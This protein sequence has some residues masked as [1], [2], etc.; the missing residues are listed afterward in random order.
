MTSRIKNKKHTTYKAY[1]PRWNNPQP[2]WLCDSKLQKRLAYNNWRLDFKPRRFIDIPTPLGFRTLCRGYQVYGPVTITL[3]LANDYRT[4]EAQA[5]WFFW[6]IDAN[7]KGFWALMDNG[8]VFKW[9]DR[10]LE[11]VLMFTNRNDAL[12]AKL[13]GFVKPLK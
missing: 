12:L 4:Q 5:I 8:N 13:G 9:G 1:G 11:A 2:A 10:K 7:C 3:E 6:N